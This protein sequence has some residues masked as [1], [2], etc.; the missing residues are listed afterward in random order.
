MIGQI[1]FRTAGEGSSVSQKLCD[2]IP[3]DSGY[4]YLLSGNHLPD[5][6]AN[7]TVVKIVVLVQ[8][9]MWL[10]VKCISNIYLSVCA[11]INMSTFLCNLTNFSS[12]KT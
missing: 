12:N 11:L 4:I 6:F 5:F 1:A 8:N 7:L 2:F 3:V 10:K 9:C